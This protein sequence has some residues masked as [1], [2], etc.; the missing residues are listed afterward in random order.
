MKKIKIT[1]CISVLILLL[2]GCSTYNG[3]L[4]AVK[5]D[6]SNKVY[7]KDTCKLISNVEYE[8]LYL[9]DDLEQTARLGY[10]PCKTCSPPNNIKVAK[11]L[12]ESQTEEFNELKPK[13]EKHKEYVD[14][15]STASVVISSGKGSEGGLLAQIDTMRIYKTHT[16]FMTVEEF[17]RYSELLYSLET[18]KSFIEK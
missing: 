13:F 6:E 2:V 7:H 3:E 5:S 15:I 9:F 16:E 11:E 1:A 12:Y 8:N 10:R 4:I 17:E 18:L 14:D